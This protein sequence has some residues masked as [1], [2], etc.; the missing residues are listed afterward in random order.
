MD[1]VSPANLSLDAWQEAGRGDVVHV[2]SERS[3]QVPVP[4]QGNV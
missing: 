1:D 2:R 4:I 3:T